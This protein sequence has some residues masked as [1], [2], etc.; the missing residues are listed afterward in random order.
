MLQSCFFSAVVLPVTVS[1]TCNLLAFVAPLITGEVPCMS[2]KTGS[3]VIL[4]WCSI[5]FTIFENHALRLVFSSISHA[6]TLHLSLSLYGIIHSVGTLTKENSISFE[7]F[8]VFRFDTWPSC[9]LLHVGSCYLELSLSN[10]LQSYEGS[11]VPYPL[12]AP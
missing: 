3:E 9:D 2:P 7:R 12:A 4:T 6:F 10:F 8:G 1:F 5:N 11:C